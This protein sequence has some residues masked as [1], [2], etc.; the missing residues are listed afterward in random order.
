MSPQCD[1]DAD[2]DARPKK[3]VTANVAWGS[4]ATK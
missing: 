4:A 2:A 3:L 1:L